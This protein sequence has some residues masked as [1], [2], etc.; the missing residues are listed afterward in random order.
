MKTLRPLFIVI[1]LVLIV[2]MAC[3]IGTPAN[4]TQAPAPTQPPAEPTVAEPPTQAPEPTAEPTAEQPANTPEPKSTEAPAAS[5]YFTEEF[6]GNI[7]NYTYFEFH[8]LYGSAK[9]DETII[10]TTKNGF[11]VFDLKKKDKW[12]YVTYD[13][14]KYGNVR[15]DIKADNRGKN[16]NNVSLI[17]R[18]S[19]EG[20]YELNIANSGL[21]SI[22]AYITSDNRY[23]TIYD[24]ASREI[25]QGK[26]SNEYTFICDDNELTAGINGIEVKTITDTKHK[27]RDGLTGFGVSSFDVIPILVE[28]DSFQISKP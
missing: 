7:D 10:P 18:Y 22:L 3:V 11:L 21:Y 16:S 24:G 4:P 9:T 26:D 15:L 2:G 6:D 28:I 19:D 14:F 27:L 8:E 5:E 12:V 1:S 17:C 13:P 20:W 25:K 23:Y